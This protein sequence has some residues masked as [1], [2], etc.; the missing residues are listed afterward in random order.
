MTVKEYLQQINQCYPEMA[1]PIVM[2]CE[3]IWS[4]EACYGYCAQAL[5]NLGASESEVL[6]VL[7]E[8]HA[9]FDIMTVY[10]AEKM[11]S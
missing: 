5:R 6:T 8:L 11:A 7:D 1:L 10:E 2:D 9:V 3:Y 4:N